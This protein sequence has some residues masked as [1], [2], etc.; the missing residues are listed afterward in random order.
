MLVWYSAVL[1]SRT[2]NCFEYLLMDS[3]LSGGN[4]PLWHRIWEELKSNHLVSMTINQ[5]NKCRNEFGYCYRFTVHSLLHFTGSSFFPCRKLCLW[6]SQTAHRYL[7]LA[8]S[9]SWSERSGTARTSVLWFWAPTSCQV[10]SFQSSMGRGR[11][12]CLTGEGHGGAGQW[13]PS[14]GPSL[15]INTRQC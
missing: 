9:S 11:C 6:S 13:N 10:L 7:D 4:L 3:F 15:E 5:S 14:C 1:F 2:L 12:R 8:T